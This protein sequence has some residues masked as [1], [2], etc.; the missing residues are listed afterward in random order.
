MKPDRLSREIAEKLEAARMTAEALSMS[1]GLARDTVGRWIR[2][3]TVPTLASLRAIEAALGDR[4]GYPVD[5]SAAAKERRSAR[6]HNRPPHESAAEASAALARN[7]GIS[8]GQHRLVERDQVTEGYAN[9]SELLGSSS[10]DA[11][12]G[13]IYV[14]ERIA[15]ESAADHP[16]IVEI[17]CSFVRRRTA[18][19]RDEDHE[20]PAAA[21]C[22]PEDDIQA[23]LTVIA[24]REVS[25]DCRYVNLSG[26][27][28]TGAHLEDANL[29]SADLRR[30]ILRD[31][32]LHGADLRSARLFEADLSGAYLHGANM[33]GADLRWANMKHAWANGADFRRAIFWGADLQ[34]ADLHQAD[35]RDADLSRK[36]V[37]LVTPPGADYSMSH[38]K[39][40]FPAGWQVS[41]HHFPAVKMNGA[42]LLGAM[43][44]GANLQGV[45]GLTE[46]QLSSAI[47]YSGT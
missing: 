19:S 12:I 22:S 17:L 25:Q 33:S 38:L 31:A 3:T 30:V 16:A 26:A 34:R 32:H 21:A 42:I 27:N 13:A 28:L 1:A 14:L 2:G 47:G 36:E 7:H 18:A 35:L 23:A 44:E 46:E 9:A 4:L 10:I 11:R 8:S 6:Q 5:L 15:R 37:A 43:M 45:E 40:P 20:E 24:R 41:S 29:Q 39:G